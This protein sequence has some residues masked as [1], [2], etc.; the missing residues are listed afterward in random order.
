MEC[1]PR[2]R[3]AAPELVLLSGFAAWALATDLSSDSLNLTGVFAAL[4]AGLLI[5]VASKRLVLTADRL[6]FRRFGRTRRALAGSDI[7]ELRSRYGYFDVVMASERS[8][9]FQRAGWSPKQMR[10]LAAE[11]GVPYV[12]S[13]FT[14]FTRS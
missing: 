5:E 13:R 9:T 2:A 7:V 10:R 6:E 8:L 14:R 3:H 11:L 4:S 1:R 12:Q